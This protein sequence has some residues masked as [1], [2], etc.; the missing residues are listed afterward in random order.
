MKK[1]ILNLGKAL[2]KVE[3]KLVN[4]G[5]R[6]GC[7]ADVHFEDCGTGTGTVF[8]SYYN[9]GIYTPYGECCVLPT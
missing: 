7:T 1:Q 8:Y 9:G 2:N 3:Q 5:V 4:G 6:P